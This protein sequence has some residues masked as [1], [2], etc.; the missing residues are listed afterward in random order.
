MLLTRTVIVVYFTWLF[1][2][3]EVLSNEDFIIDNVMINL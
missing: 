3:T 2:L 1:N